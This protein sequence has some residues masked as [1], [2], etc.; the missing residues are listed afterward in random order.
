MVALAAV[1]AVAF[2]AGVAVGG[3]QDDEPDTFARE[4]ET[5]ADCLV[6]ADATV[7]GVE[8]DDDGGFTLEFEAGFFDDF[9]FERFVRAAT[10]CDEILP[11]EVLFELFGVP[12]DLLVPDRSPLDAEERFPPP[13]LREERQRRGAAPLEELLDEL[14]PGRVRQLCRR[15]AESD[16]P[17]LEDE[18]LLRQLHRVCDLD[19]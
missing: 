3:N 8:A 18:R 9:E 6:D 14:A 4:L 10:E 2:A 13:D 12:G 16:R 19:G 5:W 15:L 17:P 1:A 11:L 7:P